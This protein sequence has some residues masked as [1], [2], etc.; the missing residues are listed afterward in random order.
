MAAAVGK[1]AVDGAEWSEC[2]SGKL[3][4]TGGGWAGGWVGVVVAAERRRGERRRGVDGGF[5]LGVCAI[6]AADE[7]E[8][9]ESVK[10]GW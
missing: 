3:G 1:G 9:S 8:V 6:A 2:G 10:G 7:A 4:L 5:A